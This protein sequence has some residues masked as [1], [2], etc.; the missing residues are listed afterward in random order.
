MKGK[1]KFYND[2]KHFG[3]ISGEDGKDYFVHASQI[4]DN[5]VLA[6]DDEV[7]FEGSEGDR[8]LV[9]QSVKKL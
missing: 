5:V 9:A 6:E 4:A 3:F 2:R 1:V 8:G 7:E